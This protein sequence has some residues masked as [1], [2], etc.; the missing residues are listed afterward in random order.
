MKKH[1]VI[2]IYNFKKIAI[3]IITIPTTILL[4]IVSILS[5]ISYDKLD[6]ENANKRLEEIFGNIYFFIIIIVLFFTVINIGISYSYVKIKVLMDLK[7]ISSYMIIF[8]I[9]ISGTIIIAI[10]LII[11]SFNNCSENFDFC[12]VGE[13]NNSTEFY[14]DNIMLYINGTKKKFRL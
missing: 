2:N 11:L 4:I 1:F 10:F 6:N 8:Y 13:T 7:Y 9:G 14:I 5:I 3:I 12:S